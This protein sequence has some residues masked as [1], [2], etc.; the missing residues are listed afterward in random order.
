MKFLNILEKI[1]GKKS[2]RSTMNAYGSDDIDDLKDLAARTY[3]AFRESIKFEP[4]GP[5]SKILMT[6]DIDPKTGKP[7]PDYMERRRKRREARQNKGAVAGCPG[8]VK[9]DD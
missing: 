6:D 8:D 3:S 4:P 5:K 1:V 2:T 7:Y 9:P